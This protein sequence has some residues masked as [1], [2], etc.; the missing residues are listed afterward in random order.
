MIKKQSLRKFVFNIYEY[1]AEEDTRDYQTYMKNERIPEEIVIT[2]L[3]AMLRYFERRYFKDFD[4][5]LS[6]IARE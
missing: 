2:Q 3:R 5:S 1:Q 6:T 4:A